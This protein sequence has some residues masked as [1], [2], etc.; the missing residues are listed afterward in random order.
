MRVTLETA[1]DVWTAVRMTLN[2]EPSHRDEITQF[3]GGRSPGTAS[4]SHVT[5]AAPACRHVLGAASA[6]DPTIK[7]EPL[8][9]IK[10]R[11]QRRG[12]PEKTQPLCKECGLVHAGGDGAYP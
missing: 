6:V 11:R 8:G 5:G 4:L 3:A 1:T 12:T 2:D 10:T 9:H 7:S